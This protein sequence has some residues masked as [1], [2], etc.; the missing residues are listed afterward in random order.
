MTR[1][2]PGIST[3][4]FAIGGITPLPDDGTV[5][6]IDFKVLPCGSYA[7]VAT[8]NTDDLAFN[9]DHVR[10]VNCN[11]FNDQNVIGG[12]SDRRLVPADD[13]VDRSLT[14]NGGAEISNDFGVITIKCSGQGLEV[15]EQS[16][17]MIMQTG[18]FS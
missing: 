12:T 13:E 3:T 18:G 15:V 8:V 6:G 14:M 17:M 11:L 16:Q 2:P 9:G 7:I 5:V 1:E 4:T 10:T